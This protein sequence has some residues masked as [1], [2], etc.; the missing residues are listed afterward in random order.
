MV[1]LHQ[2][3]NAD[4]LNLPGI[5][6]FSRKVINLA[7]FF[8]TEIVRNWPWHSGHFDPDELEVEI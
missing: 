2:G 5:W 3:E 1:V 8:A 7:G 6:P 4:N